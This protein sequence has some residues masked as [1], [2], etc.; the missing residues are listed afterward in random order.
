MRVIVFGHKGFIGSTIIDRFKNESCIG[1][2]KLDDLFTLN[3]KDTDVVINCAGASNISDSFEDPL[4]DLHKNTLLVQQLLDKIRQSYNK[5]IRFVNLSSAAIYG[6]PQLLPIKENSISNPI[7]PYGF[8]KKMAEDLC[9]EY[10]RCFGIKTISLR[11]FSAYGPGQHKMLLWDLHQ[12]IIKSNGEITLFGTG[13]ESR[14]F[15]HIEDIFQ[16]LLLAI[17]NAEFKG[18]ALNVA[19]GTEVQIK[20][21]AELYKKYHPIPFEYTFNNQ[22]RLGDPLN[23]CADISKMTDWGYKQKVHIERGIKEYILSI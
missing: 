5:N 2:D 23:W 6:D 10:Y 18:E 16:Q 11:I 22:N 13:T 20:E 4:N 15:I 19:N 3:L 7:S 17:N 21:I 8:H 14:D 12:K 1:I 9:Y